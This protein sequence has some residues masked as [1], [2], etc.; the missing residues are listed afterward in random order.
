MQKL[1][2]YSYYWLPPLIT[3]VIITITYIIKGV[4]PFGSANI[5]YYDMS[6]Q[7]IPLYLRGD[8]IA[9]GN[10]SLLFDWLTGAGS[11]ATGSY[12]GY[13]LSPF[14]WPF[15]FI[16]KDV[17]YEFLSLFLLVKLMMA[18]LSVSLYTKKTYD[19]P[20][21]IHTALAVMFTFSGYVVQD[22]TNI[23][24]LDTMILLPLIILSLRYMF[25]GGKEWPYMLLIAFQLLINAYLGIMTLIFVLFYAF[26]LYLT[27]DDISKR[28]IFAA[29]VG[30][31][32]FVGIAMAAVTMIP[33]VMK[34]SNGSRTLITTLNTMDDILSARQNEGW[35]QKSFIAFNTEIAAAFAI[36]AVVC[37]IAKKRKLQKEFIF[38]LYMFVLMLMPILS[39]G[40]HL[41]WHLGSYM[42]F[43]YRNGYMFVFVSLELAAYEY[44][45]SKAD[46]E[47]F[48]SKK[49]QKNKQN[50][51]EKHQTVIAVLSVMF[52]LFGTVFLTVQDLAF[53]DFGI[54]MGN[55]Y[56][57]FSPLIYFL[58]IAAFSLAIFITAKRLKQVLI[59][60][61]ITINAAVT[62]VCF[63]APLKYAVVE[64]YNHYVTRDK[65]I[66][67]SLQ[68]KNDFEFKDDD[69]SRVKV[70]MPSLQMNYPLVA[71]V[72][73]LAQ[74]TGETTSYYFQEVCDLGYDFAYLGNLDS[75][76]TVFSDALLN[77]RKL[78]VYG[79]TEVPT[80][81]YSNAQTSGEYSV[82]D[83][84]YTLPFGILTDEDILQVATDDTPALMHQE[85]IYESLSD[86]E[87][88]ITLI[89]ETAEPITPEDN[90]KYDNS[91]KIKTHIDK[92]SVIYTYAED[93]TEYIVNGKQITFGYFDDTQN[94]TY[95]KPML[96]GIRPLGVFESSDV[97]IVINTN[98]KIDGAETEDILSVGV[99]D[100][101]KMKS[102]SEKY[103]NSC[104]TS[105]ET[106]KN[107]L[108][109][110][111]DV[112]GNN[113]L[114]LPL[115]Y[116]E[117]WK[118]KV[119]DEPT[120]V[121]PVMNGAFMAIN[122]PDGYCEIEMSYMPRNVVMGA[123]ISFA[124]IAAAAF[125]LI[126]KKYGKDISEI[127][128]VQSVANVV[129]FAVSVVG[130]IFV[131]INPLLA[132]FVHAYKQWFYNMIK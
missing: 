72:P 127:K 108:K 86:D 6:Q 66:K 85:N 122:V 24:F 27:Q 100:L 14:S 67:D 78:L 113:Y 61:I 31:F 106:G 132:Y 91:Y 76:G 47:I 128:F 46:L 43:P 109:L 25:K 4:Y 16:G 22:Y 118:V 90:S 30:L 9:H 40:V 73:S 49:K 36:V 125:L 81:L 84:N 54:H 58:N 74:W 82:Y 52:A 32:T 44:L 10:G 94:R 107:H 87:D 42:H 83:M 15:L 48:K 21:L 20:I 129:F 2:K 62:S 39:E 63:I 18:S 7:Y 55:G 38:R 123:I 65:P 5:A 34:W 51:V 99:L 45:H 116:L 112:D 35:S 60:S 102:L 101:E 37:I 50:A 64:E 28:K 29:K 130:L 110:T 92:P 56:F 111:A 13:I 70:Y 69:V 115:E 23:F 103:E 59:F 131:N 121:Y 75:G 1:Q 41:V 26:G 95:P 71:G 79:N 105:Y 120:D 124:G 19:L 117:G 8:S 33:V 77:N 98:I 53:V 97:E 89:T 114:F 88:F 93:S 96:T 126:M 80:E 11:D 119:N 17:V 68:I 104:V 3:L 57:K 12:P